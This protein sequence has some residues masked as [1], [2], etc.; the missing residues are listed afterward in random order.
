M[1]INV[2]ALIVIT[3]GMAA[4]CIMATFGAYEAGW[5]MPVIIPPWMALGFWL[6]AIIKEGS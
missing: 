6:G 2:E 1:E 5:P 3:L 4:V